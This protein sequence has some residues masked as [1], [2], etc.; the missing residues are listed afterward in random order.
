MQKKRSKR[1][2]GALI[3]MRDISGSVEAPWWH[4]GVAA[5]NTRWA[6]VPAELRLPGP[7]APEASIS[8]ICTL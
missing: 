1:V 4:F 5:S 3:V 6:G 8:P 2:D 7:G